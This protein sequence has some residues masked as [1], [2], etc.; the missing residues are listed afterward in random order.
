MRYLSFCTC[1]VEVEDLFFF[2]TEATRGLFRI[3]TSML[4]YRLRSCQLGDSSLSLSTNKGK[5]P[6]TY[7]LTSALTHPCVLQMSQVKV[8]FS[9]IYYTEYRILFW[10]SILLGDIVEVSLTS[11][12]ALSLLVSQAFTSNCKRSS[13][14]AIPA[15]PIPWAMRNQL[16]RR[17]SLITAPWLPSVC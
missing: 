15:F 3:R 1:L 12:L 14:M 4:P 11:I 10:A 6:A 2:D 9:H 7:C 17:K 8:P 5:D 13:I 16:L